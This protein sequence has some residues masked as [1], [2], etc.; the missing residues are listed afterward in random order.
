[1]T[2]DWQKRQSRA[3]LAVGRRLAWLCEDDL[4][5]A[6]LEK[7]I[8]LSPELIEAHF[9]LG[10]AYGHAERYQEMV[11]TLRAAIR[12]DH[13]VVRAAAVKYPDDTEP[14]VTHELPELPRELRESLA[15]VELSWHHIAR[16]DDRAGMAAL[17]RA[18]ML[19]NASFQTF[20]LL[21]ISYL[22]LEARAGIPA[23][24]LEDSAL[25]EVAPELVV[26]LSKG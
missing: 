5:I 7:A 15:L 11:A 2:D 14:P 8:K 16:G 13:R 18:L 6:A 25:K 24:A 10:I 23:G 22:L 21:A 19:S 17:E 12:L 4:A 9:E 26:I 1:M 20:I 3:L